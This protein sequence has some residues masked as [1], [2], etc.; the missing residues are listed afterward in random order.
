VILLPAVLIGSA[1]WTHRVVV[2]GAL[3]API[4]TAVALA[5]LGIRGRR[6]EGK[7]VLGADAV[8]LLDV[9]SGL[10]AGRTLRASLAGLSE[11][12]ERLVAVGGPTEALAQAV[13]RALPNHGTIAAAAVRLLDEA[14]GPAIPVVEVLAAQAADT[15][16]VRRELRSAVAAPLLQGILVGGAPL[17]VLVWLIVGGGFARALTASP[18]HAAVVVGGTV[19]TVAGSVWVTA[20]VRRSMP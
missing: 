12:L 7:L 3:I 1:P 8:A 5:W 2:A 14:G 13:V 6:D 4:P 15:D 9:L 11:E 17:V 19:M 16:R 20:I 18:A 10:M